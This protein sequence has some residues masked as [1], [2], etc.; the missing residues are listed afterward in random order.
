[1]K[2]KDREKIKEAIAISIQNGNYTTR[3]IGVDIGKDHSTISRY[4][5]EMEREDKWGI[6][7][8]ANG[9]II[10]SLQKQLA[11]EHRQLENEPFNQLPAIQK[12]I[13]YLKSGGILPRRIQYLVNVVHGMSDQL[14]VMPETLVS[15]G[16]PLDTMK[17]KEIAIE[18]WRNFLAWFNVAYPQMQKTNTIN[19]YRSFLA[20]HNINFAHGEGRR[21]GLSTTPERLGEYKDIMLTPEQIDRI[22]RLLEGESDWEAWSFMNIDLHTGARAFAMA[23]MSWNRVAFLPVFRVEQFE[24][25]IKRGDWYL[26]KEGKWWVKY[27]TE[28]CRI[29][30]ETA[31]D[32]LPK[33]RKFL[34]FDDAKSDKANALQASYFMSKMAIRFKKIFSGLN[35]SSWLNEKTR[36]YALG[37]GLY[38]NGHPLHLMRH[39]MAQYYLAATNWSLAYVASLGGWENTEVLNKCYGGIPEHIKAQIAKSIHVRFDTLVLNTFGSAL[40]GS[41]LT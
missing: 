9:S 27:P 35:K 5:S 20:A 22:N 25:K 23:S 32:R 7:R 40:H 33:E 24:P 17:R 15:F 37:D 36:I 41:L 18:Y 11:Q 29:V 2:V 21:Y 14:K 10:I 31:R 19:A 38:F 26:T 4:L 30:V 12:W 6:R 8:D 34:F 3:E 39:T 13:T 16:V 1:M 28:E